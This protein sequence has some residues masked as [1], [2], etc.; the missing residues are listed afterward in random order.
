MS[1]EAAEAWEAICEQIKNLFGVQ[2]DEP[3]YI[4]GRGRD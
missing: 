4:R 1:A 3:N 2:L